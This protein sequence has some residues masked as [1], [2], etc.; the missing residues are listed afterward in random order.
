[1]PPVLVNRAVERMLA[2]PAGEVA[3]CRTMAAASGV[4]LRSVQR[5]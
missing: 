3:R 4:P 1:M 5:I 2:E